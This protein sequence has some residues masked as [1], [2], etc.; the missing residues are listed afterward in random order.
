MKQ[1]KPSVLLQEIINWEKGMK[2][3]VPYLET[4]TSLFL[5]GEE[6][7][8]GGYFCTPLDAIT[9]ANTGMDGIH[10]TFLTDFG[11]VP[12]LD[13]AP[14]IAVL[15]MDDPRVRLVARNIRDFF[16]LHL[17]DEGLL[18]NEFDSE[19]KYNSYK[20]RQETEDLTSEWFDHGKWMEQKNLVRKTIIEK[21]G[22]GPIPEPYQYIQQLNKERTNKV[23]IKTN[24]SLGVIPI[25][26]SC[27]SLPKLNFRKIA[28]VF[29]FFE[30]ATVEQK[31]AYI[32]E[33]QHE[34]EEDLEVLIFLQKELNSMGFRLES[35]RL[36]A[37][38]D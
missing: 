38:M 16:A 14:I 5:V 25:G 3:E 36:V 20:L 37:R 33:Y 22:I 19:E 13:E 15:P 11:T 18:L 9:F 35:K 10:F 12:K 27:E 23:L 34:F 31:L 29:E 17:F 6:K 21:F 1:Y 26:D 2:S 32:R 30:T 28:N 7:D 8:L 24:D 4:P